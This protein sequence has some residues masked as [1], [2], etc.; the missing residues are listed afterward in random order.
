MKGPLP[1]FIIN[2]DMSAGRLAYQKEQF[3]RMGMAF[4]RVPAVD[5]LALPRETYERY[6]FQ[7]ERPMSHSEVACLLSHS[8][9]WRRAAEGNG[10]VIME[11]DQ[12]LADEIKPVLDELGPRDGAQ[13]FNLE[14]QP[15]LRYVAR[16]PSETIANVRFFELK[17]PT[18]GAGAYLVTRDAA[19]LLLD[20][21]ERRAAIADYFIHSAPGIRRFQADPGLTL[22]LR[23]MTGMYNIRRRPEATPVISRNNP[24]KNIVTRVFWAVQHPRLRLRRAAS[25]LRLVIDKA[26]ISSSSIRR[27]VEPCASILANYQAMDALMDQKRA[28]AAETAMGGATR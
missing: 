28:P 26:R 7:W 10:A 4:E 3:D 23:T 14:T 27:K 22:E 13:L 2:L 5:G 20:R 12:V 11:D 21:L 8:L 6:A 9:G 24:R 17:M 16:Q 1:I 15:R 19:R 25:Q 18:A